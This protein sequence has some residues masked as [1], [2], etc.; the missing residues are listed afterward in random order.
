MSN[1]ESNLKSE[2]E[3]RILYIFEKLNKGKVVSKAK[4]LQIFDVDE[5]TIRRDIDKIR[6]YY[7]QYYGLDASIVYN[8]AKGGYIAKTRLCLSNSEIFALIKMLL[9]NRTFNKQETQNL[10]DH[11]LSMSTETEQKLIKDMTGYASLEYENYLSKR[12]RPSLLN[13]LWE[14]AEHIKNRDELIVK[15]RKQDN[16]ENTHIVYPVDIIFSE[17]YFYLIVYYKETPEKGPRIFR[18]DR[19]LKKSVTDNRFAEEYIRCYKEENFREK[20]QLMYGGEKIHLQFRFWG[21]SI[22]AVMDRLENAEKKK[23]PDGSYL[24][25]AVVYDKGIKMWLLSQMEFVEVL[26]PESFRDDFIKTLKN[27]ATLYKNE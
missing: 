13:L 21:A 15:T 1:K 7:L 4:L 16:S 14:L 6:R 12:E 5:K 23:L 22:D 24:V 11:L 17:Y 2:Q 26:S 3:L 19:I 27:M 20:L 18:V 10:Y 8:R 9:E 25:K